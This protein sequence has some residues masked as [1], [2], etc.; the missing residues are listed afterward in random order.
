MISI[1][2][3]LLACT[4]TSVVPL[5]FDGPIA[6]ATLAADDGP[7]REPTGYV[8]NLRSG[9]VVPL[10]LKHGR[11]LTDDRVAS[12]VRASPV[13]FGTGRLL[14]DVGVVGS[15]NEVV[16]W[17]I[18]NARGVAV[19]APYITSVDA[20][21]VPSEQV[22]DVEAPAFALGAEGSDLTLRQLAAHAG[23]TTT[24]TWTFAWNGR[25]WNAAGSRA[26]RQVAGPVA[27]VPWQSEGGEISFVLEGTP[28]E[29]EQFTVE[30]R[31]GL[32]EHPVGARAMALA[33]HA[34]VVYVSGADGRVA[35]F[36]GVTGAP[37]GEVSLPAGA[38][39]G[40]M[41][42]APDGRLFVADGNL[43]VVWRL[44]FDLDPDPASVPV[45]RVDTT[46]PVVDVAWQGGLD[47]EDAAFDHLFVAV[48]GTQ[49]V[50][51]WD[52]AAGAWFDPNPMTPGVEGIDLGSPITG[53]S[54]SLG[55][56]KLA[57]MDA[58]GAIP[59]V[60]TVLA[61]AGDGKVYHL[62]GATGCAVTDIQGPHASLASDGS[63][64]V[65]LQDLGATS[66]ADL[67]IDDESDLAVVPSPCGGVT[68]SESWT[69]IYDSAKLGW[70]VEGT[71]SG[72]QGRMARSG[73]RYV[74]DTGAV[75]FLV[76]EGAL[77]PTDG[78]RFAFTMDAGLQ[79]FRCSDNDAN[80]ACTSVD[81]NW[82][83]PGRPA[84]FETYNGATG[85]GWDEVDRRQYMM[86]PV[87][88]TDIVARLR[89]DAGDSDVKWQ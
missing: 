85:G 48:L 81:T 52:N 32:T 60:P 64:T 30:T 67:V 49:R 47:A 39:P 21:G 22:P 76:V 86:L 11:L 31:S 23:R 5:H 68:R 43:P 2:A 9:T 46:G 53:L 17:A 55:A 7:F 38:Q 29:G 58:W 45:E 24:E 74:S 40:R 77:P 75:S 71:R 37:R 34:G 10:D 35:L 66:N 8:A 69:V 4:Q 15:G 33:V 62:E 28:R 83:L 1:L 88:N 65:A 16:L 72:V 27:G 42:A 54:A 18:D 12:F 79:V 73:E 78:D 19:R 57:R 6:A 44:R 63:A 50:D 89:L 51:V 84:A 70:V 82:D 26:A 56:V 25:A 36:D 59:R 20:E 13:A 3:L 61:A 87:T 41:S 80:S 14:S